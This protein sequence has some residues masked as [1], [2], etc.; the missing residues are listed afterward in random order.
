LNDWSRCHGSFEGDA[1]RVG[2][3][4][5]W[6][7]GTLGAEVCF[8]VSVIPEGPGEI[9][10]PSDACNANTCQRSM[11]PESSSSAHIPGSFYEFGVLD[12]S[13]RS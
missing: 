11:T 10:W 5:Q 13:C 1:C 8:A 3:T 2:G 7:E 4:G 6:S 12:G 9:S